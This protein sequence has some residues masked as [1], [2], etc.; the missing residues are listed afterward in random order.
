LKTSAMK[1]TSKGATK[2]VLPVGLYT[3]DMSNKYANWRGYQTK[4]PNESEYRNYLISLMNSH[5]EYV[6]EQQVI[7]Y[8]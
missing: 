2:I 6:I 1:A 3:L 7:D 8:I 5:K 4:T